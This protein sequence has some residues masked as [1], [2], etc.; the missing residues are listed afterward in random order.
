MI[1]ASQFDAALKLFQLLATILAAVA[2]VAGAVW[3][4]IK[5]K[6]LSTL[7]EE[8]DGWKGLAE[9]RAATIAELEKDVA[10]IKAVVNELQRDYER[11]VKLNLRLQAREDRRLR[12]AHNM[13]A[14]D[15][16]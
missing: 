15:E 2:C 14:H 7:K 10:Q 13:E 9:Q 4:A 12:E 3:Y 6:S 11:V 16:E 5:G 8:R 1:Q